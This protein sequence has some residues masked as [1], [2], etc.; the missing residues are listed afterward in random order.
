MTPETAPPS[1]EREEADKH[2]SGS[3]ERRPRTPYALVLLR[4]GPRFGEID[5]HTSSHERFIDSLIRRNLIL[6]GGAIEDSTAFVHAAYI[7]RC[8]DLEQAR[9][10][11]SEDPLVTHECARVDVFRWHLVAINPDAIA[12]SAVITPADV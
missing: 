8:D 10:L 7:L 4:E 11:A 1:P 6:L 9:A 12:P 5:A 3:S 2:A